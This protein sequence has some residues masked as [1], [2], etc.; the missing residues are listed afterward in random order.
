MNRTNQ[1]IEAILSLD[2][3]QIK[4]KLIQEKG[5]KSEEVDAMELWYKRFLI[6]HAKYP[7]QT[8]VPNEAIDVIW[9]QHILDTRKYA[10]DCDLIFGEFVHHNP[11][12]EK[13]DGQT[14]QN[15]FDQTNLFYRI[16]FGEDCTQMF[17]SAKF[18]TMATCGDYSVNKSTCDK[19][20]GKL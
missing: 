10:E 7:D 11:S 12:Y 15:D 14:L 19:R 5:Y 17:N 3:S 2:L 13:A 18:A 6:L 4:G 16:E 1:T 8:H 20:P 9:H